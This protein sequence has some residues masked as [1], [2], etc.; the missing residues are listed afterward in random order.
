MKLI[1]IYKI[2]LLI[3]FL[4]SCNDTTI[5]TIS[6]QRD[7]YSIDR[8]MYLYGYPATAHPTKYNVYLNWTGVSGEGNY[9]ISFPELNNGETT[10]PQSSDVNEVGIRIDD[11]NYNPGFYFMAWVEDD[12]L[13]R[14]DST[15]IK[16]KEILWGY[17]YLSS[18][19]SKNKFNIKKHVAAISKIIHKLPNK[20]SIINICILKINAINIKWI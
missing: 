19:F 6:N 10:L 2:I 9:N 17:F 5:P 13:G 14:L 15:L 4:M 11:I 20:L 3:L 12:I 16:T 8:T 7:P 1:K 18:Y